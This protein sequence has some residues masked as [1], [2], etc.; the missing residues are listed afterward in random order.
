MEKY[1]EQCDTEW[2]GIGSIPNSGLK[3][4]EEYKGFDAGLIPVNVPVAKEHPAC[5]CGEVLRGVVEPEDCKLFG[6][7]CTPQTPVGP[8]MVSSEGT[9][10]A[11]YKYGAIGI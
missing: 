7:V 4:R 8:C 5:R 10:S 2:R 3:L 9:C 1:F 11:H 6:A